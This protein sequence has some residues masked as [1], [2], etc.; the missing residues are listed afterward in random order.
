MLP[1]PRPAQRSASK[2]RALPYRV[3]LKDVNYELKP[4]KSM[5]RLSASRR[6]QHPLAKPAVASSLFKSRVLNP[7]HLN[8]VNKDNNALSNDKEPDNGFQMAKEDNME[9]HR[10]KKKNGNDY[11]YGYQYDR[12]YHH[13]AQ[14]QGYQHKRGSEPQYSKSTV[15]SISGLDLLSSSSDDDSI[16]S[17]YIKSKVSYPYLAIRQKLTLSRPQRNRCQYLPSLS[18]S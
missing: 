9:K 16:S 12:H 13:G 15:K 3:I 2:N 5:H 8:Q 10:M 6:R 17:Q 14:Q 11:H 7:V 4:S 1:R 18:K